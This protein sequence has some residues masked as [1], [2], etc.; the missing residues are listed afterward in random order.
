MKQVL[1]NYNMY[2]QYVI[3]NLTAINMQLNIRKYSIQFTFKYIY[4][5]SIF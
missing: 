5:I 1:L 3:I 2:L 4:I